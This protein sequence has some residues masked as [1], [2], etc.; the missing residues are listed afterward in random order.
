MPYYLKSRD[1]EKELHKKDRNLWQR[2]SFAVRK[3][4]MVNAL[5]VSFMTVM[6]AGLLLL[7]NYNSPTMGCN[8]CHNLSRGIRMGVPPVD[9]KD[10]GKIP[11]VEDNEWMM[12]HW[13][14]PTEIW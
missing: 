9:F 3:K 4:K 13:F 2:I 7:G 12:G 6:L 10:R 5:F 14:Y 1:T 11:K 8:S